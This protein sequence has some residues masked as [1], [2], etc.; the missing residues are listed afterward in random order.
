MEVKVLGKAFK[1]IEVIASKRGGAVLPG[2]ILKAVAISQ[3]TCIRL[4]KSLVALGYLAQVSRQKGY[5]L[6]P[7]AFWVAGG[8]GYLHEL[9]ATAE[10]LVRSCAE[11]LGQSVLLAT[12]HEDVR[13]IL[14]GFDATPGIK[15]DYEQPFYNDLFHTVSGRV[16]LAHAPEAELT[17]ILRK[18]GVPTSGPWSPKTT[19]QV[20]HK[21][22]ERIRKTGRIVD[23]QQDRGSGAVP[24]FQDGVCIAVLGCVW[25]KSDGGKEE[26]FM[27]TLSETA[28]RLSS[29]ISHGT[30]TG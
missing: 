30:H 16:L 10:P 18:R 26:E 23:C 29:R 27:T 5:I 11:T 17:R 21:E 25:L 8:K 13:I 22:M 14:C 15:L 9:T 3:P 12:R 19:E 6:G 1:I 24:V 28:R 2:E 4:L 7:L 20:F